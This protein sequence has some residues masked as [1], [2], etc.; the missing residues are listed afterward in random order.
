M[1]PM[2]ISGQS[3]WKQIVTCERIGIVQ[4]PLY[5]LK[6]FLRW[7]FIFN[8]Q[9]FLGQLCNM[10]NF[11]T[12]FSCSVVFENVTC[13]TE[14]TRWPKCC[15]SFYCLVEVSFISLVIFQSSGLGSLGLRLQLFLYQN[16]LMNKRL[17]DLKE[18]VYNCEALVCVYLGQR[19][20]YF[21]QSLYFQFK[22]WR[23]YLN[24]K[25]SLIL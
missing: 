2:N 18:R 21:T 11:V 8:L 22:Y 14:M 25:T 7:N 10:Y 5:Y 15:Y 6:T 13:Y 9:F 17:D 23:L 3:K 16:L 1:A 12:Y 24:I 20:G 19:V 4:Q